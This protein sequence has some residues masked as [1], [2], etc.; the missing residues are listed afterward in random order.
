MHD[1]LQNITRYHCSFDPVAGGDLTPFTVLMGS[2]PGKRT[3]DSLQLLLSYEGAGSLKIPGSFLSVIPEI[4]GLPVSYVAELLDISKSTYYRVKNERYLDG[5]T[6]DKISS[7]LKIFY[8]GLLTFEGS[9]E[10]FH[11]WLNSRIPNLDHHRPIEL[12]KTENGR[13]SVLEAI[14][15]IEYNLYG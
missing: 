3:M 1:Q 6:A 13:I 2:K 7:V 9:K 4:T 14:D 15:R 10:G 8:R 5:E 12:L 11:D